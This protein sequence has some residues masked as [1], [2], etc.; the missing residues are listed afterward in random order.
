MFNLSR[1]YLQVNV[2]NNQA[3]PINLGPQ[4]DF[5][6]NKSYSIKASVVRSYTN[7]LKVGKFDSTW[8]DNFGLTTQT[9]YGAGQTGRAL[10]YQST[11]KF[12]LCGTAMIFGGVNPAGTF[13]LVRCNADGTTDTTFNAGFNTS[14]TSVS[15]A[16]IGGVYVQ[17]DN[18]IIIIGTTA[19]A[20]GGNIR[21]GIMRLNADG[22][23]DTAFTANL[24]AQNFV[25]NTV[26]TA[27]IQADGKIVIGGLFTTLRNGTVPAVRIA[28]L[29]SDGT[30]DTTF[31]S[32]FSVN[33]PNN[34]VNII[35]QT[36]DTELVFGGL[37]TTILGATQS[38][39]YKVNL[40]GSTDAAFNANIIAGGS[41]AAVNDIKVDPITSSLWLDLSLTTWGA[42]TV[43]RLFRL[44][45]NGTQDTTY[46]TNAGTGFSVASLIKDSLYIDSAGACYITY[47]SASVT[48]NGVS[49][50]LVSRILPTGFLDTTFQGN[51]PA[52]NTSFVIGKQV[53]LGPDGNS[54]I[55]S[56]QISNYA[57]AVVGGLVKIILNTTTINLVSET[58][59]MCTY[60]GTSWSLVN[61]N[62]TGMPAQDPNSG[63]TVAASAIPNG[64]ITFSI[65]AGGALQYIST[66]MPG[67][68]IIDQISLHPILT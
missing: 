38:G 57:G 37:F 46:K 62:T 49:V 56:S 40:S 61:T 3:T 36:P 63:T 11:G 24:G 10:A 4:L 13:T 14:T 65:T 55:V 22:T 2:V 15:S 23:E 21:A 30:L 18:K 50:Q 59:L 12:I 9:P 25:N 19:L 34:T 68:K 16:T 20:Y 32:L 31:T 5:N 7:G 60:N 47:S 44:N 26:T 27:C 45:S 42:S 66:N 53:Y 17:P 52:Q 58:E 8:T 29:N 6:Q 28:R 35:R 41:S 54:I 67:T 48:Y 33:G 64:G 51:I 39:I 1:K 43:G